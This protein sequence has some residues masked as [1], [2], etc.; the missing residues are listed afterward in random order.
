MQ[1]VTINIGHM[2]HAALSM[3]H[4]GGT[5]LRVLGHAYKSQRNH[6]HDFSRKDKIRVVFSYLPNDHGNFYLKLVNFG[7]FHKAIVV[8]SSICS[9]KKTIAIAKLPEMTK[10]KQFL[11]WLFGR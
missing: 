2:A 3:A 10:I 11:L 6:Y 8:L 4:P 5:P 1:G 7:H 9:D